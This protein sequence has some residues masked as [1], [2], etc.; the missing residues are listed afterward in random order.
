MNS[1]C[2]HLLSLNMFCTRSYKGQYSWLLGY[3]SRKKWVLCFKLKK[4][5]TCTSF[6][7]ITFQNNYF[8]YGLSSARELKNTFPQ[9][10]TK[11]H[12]WETPLRKRKFCLS[13]QCHLY[14]LDKASNPL[15]RVS[16][17]LKTNPNTVEQ[18]KG[19]VLVRYYF[20]ILVSEGVS[21]VSNVFSNRNRPAAS[22][23]LL[24]SIQKACTSINKS[25]TL[26]ILLRI[27]DWR[28][29]H[30]RRTRRF[31]KKKKV[32]FRNLFSWQM[33]IL[34]HFYYSPAYIYP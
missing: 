2:L 31:W 20:D 16:T 24:N 3:S 13:K 10:L 21:P 28:N 5:T 4:K 22:R 33:I 34:Q 27:N 26:I 25:C 23:I 14:F 8:S 1:Q 19:E 9:V 17:V 29:T 6:P 12:P 30:T 32:S 15:K 11:I 7:T 18:Q